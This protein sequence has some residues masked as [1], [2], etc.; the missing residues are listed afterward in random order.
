MLSLHPL[1]LPTEK[2]ILLSF[3]FA[4]S[5]FFFQFLLMYRDCCRFFFSDCSFVG[6]WIHCMTIKSS[7]HCSYANLLYNCNVKLLNNHYCVK[8]KKYWKNS[9]TTYSY[10][11]IVFLFKWVIF[12]W[13]CTY[14]FFS[15]FRC[16]LTFIYSLT[17]FNNHLQWKES[18]L[19]KESNW[20]NNPLINGTEMVP[21]DWYMDAFFCRNYASEWVWI[22]SNMSLGE[23]KIF[24]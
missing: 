21:E 6:R 20:S 2:W 11:S 18:N 1:K 8:K 14:C 16:M 15:I 17:F 4:A 19:Q 10:N 9:F 23:W 24:L 5:Y 7:H 12:C 22:E 13:A 3:S